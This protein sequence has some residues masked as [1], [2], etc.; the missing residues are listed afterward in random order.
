MALVGTLAASNGTRA[1]GSNLEAASD[2]LASFYTNRP[3]Q[4]QHVD[5]VLDAIEQGDRGSSFSG[6]TGEERVRMLRRWRNDGSS[7]ER[8]TLGAAVAL[9]ADPFAL[10]L[11]GDPYDRPRALVLG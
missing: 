10:E 3:D 1:E 4:R 11:H 7:T 5:A 6:R 2:A 8:V 9:A